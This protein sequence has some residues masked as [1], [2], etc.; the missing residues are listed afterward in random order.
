MTRTPS[1]LTS[2][3]VHLPLLL[4]RRSKEYPRSQEDVLQKYV[5]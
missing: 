1:L 5:T 4:L 2:D 3:P